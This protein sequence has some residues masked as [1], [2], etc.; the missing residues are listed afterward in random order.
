MYCFILRAAT[1]WPKNMLWLVRDQSSC[2][3]VLAAEVTNTLQS[4]RMSLFQPLSITV[5]G[6]WVLC[7]EWSLG[8]SA[9]YQ[10]QRGLCTDGFPPLA[11]KDKV[12]TTLSCLFPGVEH[13][14]TGW[15]NCDPAAG[16]S[17]EPTHMLAMSGFWL[18]QDGLPDTPGCLPSPPGCCSDPR[19]HSVTCGLWMLVQVLVTIEVDASEPVAITGDL[20]ATRWNPSYACLLKIPLPAA[21]FRNLQAT[22]HFCGFLPCW[23]CLCWTGYVAQSLSCSVRHQANS[24]RGNWP[25]E[26]VCRQQQDTAF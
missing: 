6:C 11:Q 3:P 14:C 5:V 2:M 22:E 18:T 25:R 12:Q 21:P 15:R 4:Q 26:S 7:R 1:V 20:L 17:K 10:W 8:L 24:T 13:C 16:C 19:D 23:G 9:M